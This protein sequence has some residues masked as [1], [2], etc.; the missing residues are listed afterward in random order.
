[1]VRNTPQYLLKHR[2]IIIKNIP[3]KHVDYGNITRVVN[4]I[5]PGIM[6][7]HYRIVL[8]TSEMIPPLK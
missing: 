7:S 6:F 8:K 1:M 5:L 4:G 2:Y 3:A